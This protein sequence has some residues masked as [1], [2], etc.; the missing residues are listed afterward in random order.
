M[1]YHNTNIPSN[2]IPN[3]DN[4]PTSQEQHIHLT[5]IVKSHKQAQTDI[6]NTF[7]EIIISPEK[8]DDEKLK[9][10]Y[11]S[12]FYKIPQREKLSHEE[13]IIKSSEIIHPEENINL[14]GQISILEQD[15][16]EKNNEL[17]ALEAPEKE[18]EIFPNNTFL[19]EGDP[20]QNIT[21]GTAIWYIQKGYKR[22]ITADDKDFFINILRKI[23]RDSLYM[24]N[25][26]YI[27]LTNSPLRQLAKADEINT[28]LEAQD[29]KF[30][31]DMS[32]IP[33][34]KA[35][36]DYLTDQLK[37]E[38]ECFGVE[39]Y[40]KFDE[41]EKEAL[42]GTYLY[43][44][45][46]E[47]DG[48]WYR[49]LTAQC[50]VTY[51]NDS[52]P[53]IGFTPSPT[54][55]TFGVPGYAQRPVSRDASLYSG[56][57]L[58]AEYYEVPPTKV[59]EIRPADAFNASYPSMP[60][61]KEWGPNGKFPSIVDVKKGSR[62]R[63]KI[64]NK[65]DDGSPIYPREGQPDVEEWTQLYGIDT[66][67]YQDNYSLD[68]FSMYDK[69]SNRGTKMINNMC[70]GPASLQNR[71]YG[72]LNQNWRREDIT[73]NRNLMRIFNNP[74]SQ[75]YRVDYSHR[76]GGKSVKGKVYGQPILKVRGILSVYL[77]GYR[78]SGSD[79]NVFLNIEGGGIMNVKNRNLEDEVQ[80]YT[81]KRI[82]GEPG[83]KR[84]FQWINPNRREN[85][86]LNGPL[87]NPKIYYPGL[88]SPYGVNGTGVGSSEGQD[89]TDLSASF[90]ASA[91]LRE[92][93]I[94]TPLKASLYNI[95]NPGRPPGFNISERTTDHQ[96]YGLGQGS[97][98]GMT[99]WMVNNLNFMNPFYESTTPENE[100]FIFN[101]ESDV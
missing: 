66:Q 90:F 78:R 91:T 26:Q 37:V 1:P 10:I 76:S 50:E 20:G 79:W 74:N 55:L 45:M 52:D 67:H 62:V 6:Q 27:P 28:I 46:G 3:E 19:Q 69:K 96:E 56:D 35:N 77:G 51:V 71:C 101:Y 23:N 64:V 17:N 49:D 25:D 22:K 80:G 29:I 98:F 73:T 32:V 24:S 86:K 58:S 60:M 59:W 4:T 42:D 14:Q 30:G 57:P 41:D 63:V 84:Y 43:D 83:H 39:T 94:I 5:K 99:Q 47:P 89:Y 97:N 88:V 33:I 75:Y 92:I 38:F 48:F 8:I 12:V 31:E 13:I 16:L 15:L 7:S 2:P 70:Y 53:T 44:S 72:R 65:R 18:H 95:F 87:N 82:P 9:K 36:Q 85:G 81:R 100:M 54:I 61:I 68:I 11:E 34:A 21:I 40:Y 93:P